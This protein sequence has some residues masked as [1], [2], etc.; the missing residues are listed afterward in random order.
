MRRTQRMDEVATGNCEGWLCRNFGYLITDT[1][2]HRDG[3]QRCIRVRLRP[4]SHERRDA[5]GRERN[6][7]GTGN[8]GWRDDMPFYSRRST[9]WPHHL[10][11]FLRFHLYK[12]NKDTQEALGKIGN[13]LGLQVHVVCCFV[14]VFEGHTFQDASDRENVFEDGNHL[15]RFLDHEP[16]IMNQCYNIPKGII[17]VEL[18][19]IVELASRLRK[20]S[21]AMFEAYVSEDGKHVDYRSIEGCEDFKSTAGRPA[22]YLLANENTCLR[23]AC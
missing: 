6:R 5:G 19:P 17:D 14:E 4:G 11:K 16:I 23:A 12:E 13:M 9:T 22:G 20:L 7:K 1:I 18:K 21:H 15:Y 3:I 2:E 8:L 10:G